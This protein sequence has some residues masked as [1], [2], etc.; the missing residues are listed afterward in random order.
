MPSQGRTGERGP[1]E[2]AAARRARLLPGMPG[3][4][5]LLFGILAVAATLGLSGRER[6]WDWIEAGSLCGFLGMVLMLVQ[7]HT[8]GRQVPRNPVV[9]L[10]TLLRWH[11]AAG[12]AAAACVLLHGGVLLAAD[13]AHLAYLDPRVNLPR[14]LALWTVTGAL[15]LLAVL[16]FIRKRI[17]MS[18][19]VWRLSH[20]VLAGL[21][22]FVG[23]VHMNMVGHHVDGW[24]VRVLWIVLAIEAL[25]I[26]ADSR[27]LLPLLS[28][29]KPYVV[30]GVREEG[31]ATWTLELAARGHGGMHFAAGQHVWL[32]LGP[33][34]L[35]LQ[36]HPFTIASSEA[37]PDR[38]ELTIKELGDF[39][40]RIGETVPGTM[41]WLEGP[42]GAGILRCHPSGPLVFVAGGVGITPFASVPRTLRERG[43]RRRI[44][45]FHGAGSERKA[46]F[47][48]EMEEI[49]KETGGVYVPVIEEPEDASF[50]GERGL[51]SRDVLAR[52]AS[53]EDLARAPFILCGPGPMLRYVRRELL[54]L[55]VSRGRIFQE[56]FDIG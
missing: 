9:R 36:Q 44:V 15:L 17:G 49:L 55:G 18:Y 38:L 14:A 23:I 26:L 2:A 28:Q 46:T 42:C 31:P 11:I 54:A 4:R 50:R 47:G 30:A 34:P 1:Q 5:A 16:P 8:S 32:T 3:G 51:V 45:L 29:R 21:A 22:V 37:R 40:G 25:A 10:G 35:S 7:F 41:A 27:L 24:I 39:T 33:A 13:P 12:I 48:Q 56:H 6:R 52:R 53:R 43:L 20:G 19:E